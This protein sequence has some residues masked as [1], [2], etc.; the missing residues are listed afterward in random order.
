MHDPRFEKEV[1]QKMDGLEFIPSGSVWEN[2]ERALAPRRRR[3][4]IPVFWWILAPGLLLLGAGGA[5]YWRSATPATKAVIPMGA[6][7]ATPPPVAPAAATTAS[8]GAPAATVTPSPGTAAAARYPATVSAPGIHPATIPAAPVTSGE[9][10][11]S[12]ETGQGRTDL[13]A[14]AGASVDNGAATG[15][16]PAELPAAAPDKVRQPFSYRPGLIPSL[17]ASSGIRGPRLPSGTASLAVTGLPTRK[18]PWAAGFAGGIGLSAFNESLRRPVAAAPTYYATNFTSVANVNNVSAAK[19]YTSDIQPDIS[20]WAGVVA[21]KPLSARWSLTLGLNLHYYSSRL[22]TGELVNTYAPVFA[23]LIASPAVAPVQSYPYYSTGDQ[24]V[25]TNR[26]YYL[27]IPAAVEWQINHSRTLPLFWR[28]GAA[29]SRLMGSNALYYDNH[30]G[31]YFKDATVINHTQVSFSTALMAGMAIRGTRIQ[32]GPEVQYGVTGVLHSQAGD[33][34][35]L[36]G[37]I[38]MVILP[39]K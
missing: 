23:S 19:K 29:L 15:K 18:H 12:D 26:Y 6:S 2:V 22:H 30:S 31:V 20:F 10:R 3:R 11:A 27:E 36:Y 5:F 28:G 17:M 35:L 1:Q 14:S 33:G 24:Q 37:G 34:H 4:A 9:R 13:F 7:A 32:A 38:R 39:G 16:V 21:Q 25:F 8:P